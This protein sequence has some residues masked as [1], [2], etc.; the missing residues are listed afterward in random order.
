MPVPTPGAG[1]PDIRPLD[2]A[3]ALQ[4]LVAEVELALTEA[5]LGAG[6]PAPG[7]GTT[8]IDAAQSAAAR[9]LLS[10]FLRALPPASE[11]PATFFAAVQ[12]AAQAL[13]DGSQ[14]AIDR[15]AAWRGTPAALVAALQQGRQLSLALIS[16]DR[17]QS[18]ILAHPEC[19]SLANEWARL[20]R[21]RR[22]QERRLLLT[23]TDADWL[24]EAQAEDFAEPDESA[25]PE[26]RR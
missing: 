10:A 6:A 15:V 4:I 24:E 19:L 1:G 18:P 20:R 21:R 26:R 9:V 3:G 14:A 16:D 25:L 7:A 8:G 2:L 23:D 22:R 17:I 13:A 12:R 5:G 11:P